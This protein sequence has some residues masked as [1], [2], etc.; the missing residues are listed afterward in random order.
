MLRQVATTGNLPFSTLKKSNE[1]TTR[2]S[3][4]QVEVDKR[5]TSETSRSDNSN[6]IPYILVNGVT[7]HVDGNIRLATLPSMDALF[8]L[9]EMSDGEFSQSLKA[10][11]LFDLVVIRRD[12]ELNASSLLDESFP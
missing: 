9:I 12:V 8:E 11:N 6:N 10:E 2:Q 1:S 3:R 4:R 7:I 5:P